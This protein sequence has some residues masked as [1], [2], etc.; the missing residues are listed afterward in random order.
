LKAE[1]QS[2][3]LSIRKVIVSS[4]DS[5]CLGRELYDTDIWEMTHNHISGLPETMVVDPFFVSMV[6]KYRQR[7][8]PLP[9]LPMI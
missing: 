8:A 3:N 6:S 5:L 1:T 4:G 2:I 7:L 9:M